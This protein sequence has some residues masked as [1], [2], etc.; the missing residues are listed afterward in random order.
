MEAVYPI[1]VWRQAFPL[2][3]GFSTERIVSRSAPSATGLTADGK[4]DYT[5]HA[6]LV[7]AA[8]RF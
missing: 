2:Q 4:Y 7:T 3:F 5:S 8:F 1:T 6:V